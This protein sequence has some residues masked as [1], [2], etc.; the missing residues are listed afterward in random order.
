MK[1][2]RDKWRIILQPLD[3]N[4]EVFDPCNMDEIASYVKI[5]EIIEVS[6]HYE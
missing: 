1:S 4:K 2:R 3:E 6:A 5:I